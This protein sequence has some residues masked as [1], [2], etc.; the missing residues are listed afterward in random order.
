MSGLI[1]DNLL[2]FTIVHSAIKTTTTT[3][4]NLLHPGRSDPIL[5]EESQ[6]LSQ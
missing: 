5:P 6:E 1:E 2:T 4:K 3:T